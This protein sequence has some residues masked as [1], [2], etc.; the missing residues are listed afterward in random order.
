MRIALLEDKLQ[1]VRPYRLLHL[2]IETSHANLL[3]SAVFHRLLLWDCDSECNY[4]CQH[5][6]TS[7]RLDLGKSIQQFY[8]KW[9][10]YRFLGMQEPF[11]VLFSLGNLWA[12]WDGLNKVRT[13]IPT[14]YPMR[15]FY[16]YLANFGIA[17][18]IFSSIFHTRDFRLTEELDYFAAGA[19][20]LYGMYYTPIRVFRLDT[21]T[22]RRRSFLRFWTMFC[23][24]LYICHVFYLKFI[25]WN[26]TYNMAAN[27]MVGTAQNILWTYFSV[28]RYR[29]SKRMWAVWPS[30]VVAWLLFAMSMELFDFP[31]WFGCIDAH[32]LWHLFTIA[33]TILWYK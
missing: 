21:R 5:I 25:D 8:G 4:A 20:V 2:S 19:S 13:K 30:F 28:K 3:L 17:S 31:P 33:P 6:I 9:P 7:K 24:G 15:R 11:S 16:E 14:S 26:Y 10:F 22:P 27:V 29:E 18:W 32:S 1:F 23:V 12:H